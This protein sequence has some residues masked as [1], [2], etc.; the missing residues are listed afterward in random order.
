[1]G[2]SGC[3]I[4]F[5]FGDDEEVEEVLEESAE[6]AEEAV[7]EED[8]EDEKIDEKG[9]EEESSDEDD[10]QEF[11]PALIDRGEKELS[12]IDVLKMYYQHIEDGELEDAFNMRTTSKTTYPVFEGWYKNVNDTFAYDFEEISSHKYQFT[13][14]LDEVGGIEETFFVV[15]EVKDDNMLKNLSSKKTW[16]NYSAKVS[17]KSIN[18]KTNLYVTNDGNEKWVGEINDN[19]LGDVVKQ[20]QL[21]DYYITP[22]E[23]FL[24]YQS[25]GYEWHLLNV[26]DINAGNMVLEIGGQIDDYGFTKDYKNF[27]SCGGSGMHNGQMD[28]YYVENFSEVHSYA[29]QAFVWSCDGYNSS[30]NAYNYKILIGPDLDFDN[31]ISRTFNFDTKVID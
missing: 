25:R 12:D 11:E 5:N 6:E 22:N 4:N 13:V 24:V 23:R 21:M 18:G 15:T 9:D 19:G 30:S 7:E 17:K 27:Y 29:S 1:M 20:E 2:F 3:G 28:I 16:D 14:E 10:E 8:S 26:F 31:P